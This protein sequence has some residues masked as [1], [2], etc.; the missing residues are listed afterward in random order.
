MSKRAESLLDKRTIFLATLI[1]V[2]FALLLGAILWLRPEPGRQQ[3]G[4]F[5]ARRE[6]AAALV[7]HELYEPALREYERLLAQP[8]LPSEEQANLHYAMADLC[9]EKLHDYAQAMAHYLNIQYLHP[10]SPL[11]QE[12]G[13]KIVECLERLGRS[14]EAQVEMEAATALVKREPGSSPDK[15]KG[16]IVARIGDREIT[17]AELEKEIAPGVTDPA[18]QAQKLQQYLLQELLYNA[19]KRRGLDR[20]REIAAQVFKIKKNL[21]AQRLLQE[22]LGSIQVSDQEVELYYQAHRDR[23][24][25]RKK[26]APERPRTLS[27][28]RSQVEADLRQERL[29]QAQQQL[30][31]KLLQAENAQIFL[32]NLPPVNSGAG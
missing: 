7:E 5:Q 3:A 1:L 23:Y 17:Q 24:V 25:E 11:S 4:D 10:K 15:G 20:D 32:E 13:P 26:G 28:V 19:A 18:Q 31:Q 16:P 30:L 29:R 27:E 8:G 22:E 21:M 2:T 6:Y 12:V 14:K 9:L